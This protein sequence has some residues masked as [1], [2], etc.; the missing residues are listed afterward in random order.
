MVVAST[1]GTKIIDFLPPY[2]ILAASVT[3][4]NLVYPT[5]HP[6]LDG[7]SWSPVLLAWPVTL[8]LRG[9][10]LMLWCG[11]RRIGQWALSPA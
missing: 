7:A 11:T 9:L 5:G 3:A 6:A 8:G 10:G 2:E 1:R 4:S